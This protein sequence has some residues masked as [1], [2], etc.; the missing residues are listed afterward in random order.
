MGPAGL[1]CSFD[2]LLAEDYNAIIVLLCPVRGD[3]ITLGSGRTSGF[4]ASS[5]DQDD[6]PSRDSLGFA[7]SQA[8][9]TVVRDGAVDDG[10]AIDTFPC[11]EHEKKI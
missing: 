1:S 7:G 9:S 3:M 4:G 6:L 11:I 10:A 5:P 8:L 2:R